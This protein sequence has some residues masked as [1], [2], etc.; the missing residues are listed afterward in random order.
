MADSQWQM[1][2]ACFRRRIALCTLPHGADSILI[3]LLTDGLDA[4]RVN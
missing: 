4:P 2:S 1:A 3:Q